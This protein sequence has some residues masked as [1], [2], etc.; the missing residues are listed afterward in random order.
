MM[1]TTKKED[2]MNRRVME[3]RVSK[4][5][6]ESL[7]NAYYYRLEEKRW[8]KI[9]SMLKGLAWGV[10]IGFVLVLLAEDIVSVPL[11]D[12]FGMM[13]A[14]FVHFF[15]YSSARDKIKHHANMKNE[16]FNLEYRY[17]NLFD[18]M[19][20]SKLLELEDLTVPELMTYQNIQADRETLEKQ[21]TEPNAKLLE[22]AMEQAMEERDVVKG[23][24]NESQDL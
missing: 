5:I 10:P 1:A 4:M 11:V 14:C 18:T 15:N 9:C 19:T 24:P 2:K 7:A 17:Q 23:T 22:K 8:H 20:D 3:E 13:F 12:L 21:Q 6:T 16:W